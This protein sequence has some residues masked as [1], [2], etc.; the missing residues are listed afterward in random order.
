MWAWLTEPRLEFSFLGAVLFALALHAVRDAIQWLVD[1]LRRTERIKRVHVNTVAVDLQVMFSN[2][3]LNAMSEQEL[4]DL[5][6]ATE[7]LRRLGRLNK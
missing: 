3:T 6:K 4:T 5:S 7:T 1:R 2:E